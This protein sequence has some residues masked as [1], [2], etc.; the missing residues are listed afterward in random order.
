[1]ISQSVSVGFCCWRPWCSAHFTGATGVS[2]PENVDRADHIGV[3][4]ETAFYARE[5]GLALPVVRRRMAAARA[6]AAGVE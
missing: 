6:G 4:L 2:R 5:P 1:M 3:F